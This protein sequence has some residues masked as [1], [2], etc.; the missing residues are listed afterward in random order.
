M[1]SLD[2]SMQKDQLILK[3]IIHQMNQIDQKIHQHQRHLIMLQIKVLK[4]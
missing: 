1:Q 2:I 3:L 4:P